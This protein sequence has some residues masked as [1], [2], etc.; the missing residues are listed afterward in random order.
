MTP[1][2]E[3]GDVHLFVRPKDPLRETW[4]GPMTG[5]EGAK[6][7]FGADEAYPIADL[8]KK[9][10]QLMENRDCLYFTPEAGDS[11]STAILSV[12][13]EHRTRPKRKSPG[14]DRLED[15]RSLLHRARYLKSPDEVTLLRRA[16]EIS[17][18][19][20]REAMRLAKPGMYEYQVQAGMEFVFRT[21]GS[22]RNGYGS[23]VAAG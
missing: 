23:I 13:S 4:D 3:H 6:E 20:H 17:A 1:G 22:Q 2:G 18:A 12:M 5:L 16:G 7:D 11:T 19:G 8:L 9:L 10:S 21:L 14:P 15:F